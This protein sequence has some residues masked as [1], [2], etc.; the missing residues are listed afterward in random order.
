MSNSSNLRTLTRAAVLL[1][2]AI[3]FQILKVGGQYVTG[4]GI[5]AVL[6]IAA[7]ICGVSWACAIGSFTPLLAM[8]LGVLPQPALIPF[9]IAGNIFFVVMFS[10]LRKYN[11]Y[12]A[13]IAAALLKF[14]VLYISVNY[15]LQ[16]FMAKVPDKLIALM[17]ITQLY[18]ALVGGML[19]LVIAK[20]I[21][22]L[23]K[24]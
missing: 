20:A 19:A 8:W 16:Y 11:K 2:I 3:V 13:L 5:N 9:I 7:M 18:T 15:L 24:K 21:P 23:N 12:I 4:S 1:A 14:G 10:I 6:I 17:G 22:E